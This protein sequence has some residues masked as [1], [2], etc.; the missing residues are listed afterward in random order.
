MMKVSAILGEFVDGPI[1]VAE[2]ETDVSDRAVPVSA[3]VLTKNV[4]EILHLV[5]FFS[6]DLET[7]CA[8]LCGEG[9]ALCPT[10]RGPTHVHRTL[11]TL[12]D[13]QPSFCAIL[14]RYGSTVSA[15]MP[16]LCI[17]PEIL[18]RVGLRGY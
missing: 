18:N 11:T 2:N 4:L 7:F 10:P 15:Y 16:D 5:V 3:N 9:R 8:A 1:A 13:L 14:A 17:L 12:T 6:G